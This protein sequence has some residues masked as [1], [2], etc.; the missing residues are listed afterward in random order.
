MVKDLRAAAPPPPASAA[1]ACCCSAGRCL[2][3]LSR[4]RPPPRPRRPSDRCPWS[5][6]PI[7]PRTSCPSR[8][9]PGL[10]DAPF[11]CCWLLQLACLLGPCGCCRT[12]SPPLSMSQAC[13]AVRSEA[14]CGV[15]S[16]LCGCCVC[17]G[18]DAAR[19]RQPDTS[20]V[21]FTISCSFWYFMSPTGLE[22]TSRRPRKV[23]SLTPAAN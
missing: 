23:H 15:P 2:A 3:A 5:L 16:V 1:P 18:D 8:L 22:R 6:T 21:K 14:A 19:T 17:R 12:Q 4:P 13:W 20:A 11:R 7:L 10:P 9:I